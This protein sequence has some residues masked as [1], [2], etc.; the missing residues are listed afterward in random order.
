[1]NR[2]G[3]LAGA[4]FLITQ[5]DKIRFPRRMFHHDRTLLQAAPRISKIRESRQKSAPL[6][7]SFRERTT[8]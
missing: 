1:M 3:G 4:S 7:R 8:I 6:W 2:G 5:Y